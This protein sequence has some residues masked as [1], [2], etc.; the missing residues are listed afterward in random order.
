MENS[1]QHRTLLGVMFMSIGMFCISLNDMAVKALSG[2]YPLHE[3]VLIRSVIGICITV[4]LL[5]FEGGFAALR[6]QQP[7]LHVARALCIV[8]ANSA[9]YAAIVAMPLATASAIYFVAPLFVTLLAIPVLGEAVGPRRIA[10]VSVGFIGVL[11]ILWPELDSAA[12]LG[13][14]TA[15]PVMAAAGYAVTSVLTR[16]LGAAAPASVLAFNLQAAFILSSLAV[17]LIAGDGRFAAQEGISE[18]SRFLLR[19]WVWPERA[20]LPVLAGLGLL[21]GIVGYSMS[22][23]YRMAAA[24]VVAPFEYLLLIYSLFWGWTVFGEWPKPTVFLGAAIIVL[25]GVYIVWRERGK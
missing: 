2:G 23:A 5:R 14:V 24:A 9:F 7:G 17:Y 6:V 4:G 18:S 25:A 11:V 16:K 1:A 12:G 8:F 22:Q 21:S 10:A 20:D 15:L 13:W 3:I 19:A